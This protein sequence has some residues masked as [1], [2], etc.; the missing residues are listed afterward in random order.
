VGGGVAPL[1]SKQFILFLEF[2][3]KGILLSKQF[4]DKTANKYCT[5]SGLCLEHEVRE[6]LGP[7]KMVGVF[8]VTGSSKDSVPWPALGD[9]RC[10]VVLWPDARDW[11]DLQGL[12]LAFENLLQGPWFKKPDGSYLMLSLRPNWFWLPVGSYLV[13]ILPTGHQTVRALAEV[14]GKGLIVENFQCEANQTMYIEIGKISK[15]RGGLD[16]DQGSIVLK[17]IDP[18]TGRKVIAEMPRLLPP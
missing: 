7:H 3:E 12:L 4:G 16:R 8:T 6:G 14:T 2:N 10:V 17:T 15:S 11:K 1:V 5:A 18:E 9:D 13:L